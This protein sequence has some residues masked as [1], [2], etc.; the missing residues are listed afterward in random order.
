M[1]T[2]RKSDDVDAGR[3]GAPTVAT[4]ASTR[5]DDGPITSSYQRDPGAV[6]DLLNQ[7]L[8]GEIVCWLRYQQHSFAVAGLD[9][10]Q[11]RAEFG[12][13]ARDALSHTLSIA[14]RISQLGGAPDFDPAGLAD[15][16][17]TAYR[18]YQGNDVAGMVKENLIA[19]RTAI[20]TYQEAVRWLADGDPT[21]RR[22]LEG[23]LADVEEH[24]DDLRDLL[25][26]AG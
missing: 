4:Q 15:R 25:G 19:E 13:H 20:Q 9:S 6:I 10:R 26:G 11:V 21:T 5:L 18:V 14:E 7:I 8:A 16:S 1:S 3:A 23:I 12:E 17:E 22:L 24:A 2:S